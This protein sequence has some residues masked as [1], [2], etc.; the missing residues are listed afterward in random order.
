V[1]GRG[2]RRGVTTYK[3]LFHNPTYLLQVCSWERPE[4]KKIL[5]NVAS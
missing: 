4:V 5:K 3:Q 1:G 2:V